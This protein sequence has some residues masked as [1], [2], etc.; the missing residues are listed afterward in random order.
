[1][2]GTQAEET[3]I[4]GRHPHRAP[5]VRADSEFRQAAGH[6]RGG[7]AGRAA[8]HP[9]R[10]PGIQGGAVKEI[11]AVQTE[12]QLIADRL[13]DTGG[14]RSQ[15]LVHAHGVDRGGRVGLGPV[16]VAAAGD[17]TTKIDKVLDPETQAIQKAAPGGFDLQKLDKGP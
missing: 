1:M 10:G 17:V 7:A 2:G 13:A 16:R 5:G 15:K 3:A 9:V 11:F 12:G 6:H 14:P 4:A 8:G